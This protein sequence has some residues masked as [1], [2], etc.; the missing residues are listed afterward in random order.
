MKLSVLAGLALA[1]LSL[2]ACSSLGGLALPL[3]GNPA[4]DAKTAAAN[5]NAVNGQLSAFNQKLFEQLIQKCGFKGAFNVALPNPVPT[6]NL[7]MWCDIEPGGLSAPTG[8]GTL[9][10]SPAAIG[11]AAQT[12]PAAAPQ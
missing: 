3:T 8:Q 2:C 4:A 6:G 12:P 7:A 5:L 1:S 10:L 9:G 11:T